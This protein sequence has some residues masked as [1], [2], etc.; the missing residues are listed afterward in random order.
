MMSSVRPESVLIHFQ[1]QYD[2]KL[3]APPA[4]RAADWTTVEILSENFSVG[5]LKTPVKMPDN[6]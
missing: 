1:I 3:L 2:C 5:L 6:R 4:A